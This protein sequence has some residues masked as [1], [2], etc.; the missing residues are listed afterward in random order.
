MGQITIILDDAA[1]AA[2]RAAAAAAGVSQHRWLVDLIRRQFLAP[3]EAAEAVPILIVDDDPM[4]RESLQSLVEEL[5]WRADLAEDGAS[6]LALLAER[7]YRLLLTDCQMPFVDGF[8]L[9]RAVRAMER[10]RD[11][12]RLPI[13]AVTGDFLA[14]DEANFRK[15]GLDGYLRKPFGPGALAEVLDKWLDGG[16]GRATPAARAAMAT[17]TK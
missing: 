10:R 14:D 4:C 3:P 12:R 5:G 17:E 13:V 7:D 8:Q 2:V 9:T 16:G 15:L 1:E 11:G 6:G